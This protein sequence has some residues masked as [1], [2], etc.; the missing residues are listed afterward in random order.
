MGREQSDRSRLTCPRAQCMMPSMPKITRRWMDTTR[1]TFGKHR[2]QTYAHV[3]Q[4]D[5][6]S[7]DRMVANV[8]CPKG[9]IEACDRGTY[10]R[11]KLSNGYAY[12][13]NGDKLIYANGRW[14]S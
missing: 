11:R 12:V 8:L 13:L 10:A 2:G 4:F 6:S 9:V 14:L 7:Q 3:A 1:L 5:P